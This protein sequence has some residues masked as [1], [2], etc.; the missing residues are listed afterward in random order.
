MKYYATIE[1]VNYEVYTIFILSIIFSVSL[2]KKN[3][4]P[5]FLSLS[6]NIVCV[7][8]LFAPF[9]CLF[10]QLEK[11]T[12]TFNQCTEWTKRKKKIEEEEEGEQQQRPTQ[13]NETERENSK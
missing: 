6:L 8:M 12:Y 11:T 1:K 9:F 7:V 10:F 5:S 13:S 4:Y 2:A 3:R